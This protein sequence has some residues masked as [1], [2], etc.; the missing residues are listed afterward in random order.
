MG[1]K[2]HLIKGV[3]FF[4]IFSWCSSKLLLYQVLLCL[5][6]IFLCS[7]CLYILLVLNLL[8]CFYC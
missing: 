4:F 5:L 3:L 7:H 8:W 6:S 2:K 1:I